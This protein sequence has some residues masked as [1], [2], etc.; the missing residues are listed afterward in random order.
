MAL[1]TIGDIHGK[2]SK[3]ANKLN[4]LPTG[5]Q[6]ICVGDIGLGFPDSRTAECLSDVDQVATER[7]QQVWLIRGNHDNP[8]I[9]QTQREEWNSQLRN[10]RIARDVDRLK[11]GNVHAILVGGAISLDRSHPDRLDGHNW[12]NKEGVQA[13]ALEQVERIVDSYGRADILITHAG[14]IEAKPGPER[15][16]ETFEFYQKN[17]PSLKTDVLAERQLL[18]DI[19]VASQARTIAF[20]HYHVPLESNVGPIRYRCCAELEAWEYVKRSVLPPLPAL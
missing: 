6:I 10:I 3:L 11:I 14:P 5:A 15:D 4:E 19:L 8:D 16:T 9:W 12:W 18:S 13:S 2:F 20:G 17:D 1:Y 7:G